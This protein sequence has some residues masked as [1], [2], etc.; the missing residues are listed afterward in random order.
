MRYGRWGWLAIGVAVGGLAGGG[1]VMAHGGDTGAVHACVFDDTIAQG[2]PNTRIVGADEACPANST[3][4]DWAIA[5]PSGPTGATGPTGPEGPPGAPS[6]PPAAADIG[7]ALETVGIPEA[8]FISVRRS[9]RLDSR[10]R[11]TVAARCPPTHPEVIS[12]SYEIEPV[13]RSLRP[14]MVIG[15]GALTAGDGWYAAVWRPRYP[16]N[17]RLIV[18]ARCARSS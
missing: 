18:R 3:P 1:L 12:G 6:P 11:K 9:S 13:P 10:D 5:G 8:V 2:G 7:R 16:S 4:R 15:S 17:W 14:T